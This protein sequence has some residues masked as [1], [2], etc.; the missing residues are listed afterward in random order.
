M[1][2]FKIRL[3]RINIPD[4]ELLADLR[5]A[6]ESV[7]K[8]T[9]TVDQYSQRGSFGSTTIEKRFG[10]WNIALQKAGLQLS[11]RK[12]IS[13][14]ELFQNLAAVWTTL[15]RQPSYNQMADKV[16][17]SKFVSATY[18]KRFGS[19]NLGL[20]AF[21]NYISGPGVDDEFDQD[22][23]MGSL[24]SARLNRRTKRDVN[25]RLRAKIL[26]R[27][28][29]ICKMCGAS[30]AKSSDAILHV[31]HILA[32][33]LGGETLEENLQTLCEPCNIGKSNMDIRA[34]QSS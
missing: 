28:N 23:D 5:R 12:D 34:I 6:A 9:I 1:S 27:D 2:E 24:K 11:V 30:P 3:R 22:P 32:W 26:I 17:G 31:D 19:W 15:G 8:E 33:D 18:E 29:C 13:D 7:G 14:L 21:S 4:E 25:W 10:S 16:I 20:I